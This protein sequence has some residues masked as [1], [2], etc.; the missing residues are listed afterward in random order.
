MATNYP[1]GLDSLSNPAGSD[2]LSTGHAAQHANAND[3]IE[4]I[5]GELGLNPRGGSATVKARIDAIEANSWVTSARIADG[6]VTGTDIA[7]GTVT[8]ANLVDGTIVNADIN[9]AAA[10]DKT[11]ISGTAVTTADSGSVT[12]GM[13]LDGTIVNT[14]VNASAA[15]AATK[16]AGTA[17]TQA[18]TGTVTSAMIATGAIVD[19]DINAAAGIAATKVS[20]TAVTQADSGTVTSAMIADGTIVN[21]DIATAAAVAPSKID[22]AR[23]TFSNAA[24]VCAATTRKLAQVGTMSASRTV[25][26]PAANAVA[27]GTEIVICDESGSVTTTNT[28]VIARAGTDTINGTTSVSIGAAYG[29]RRAISDGSSKWSVDGGVVRLSDVGTITSTMIADATITGADIATGTVESANI[30]DGTI[31]NA[32]INA[33]AAIDATKIAGISASA[34]IGN[35]LTTN[36][37]SIETN[38]TG[39]TAYKCTLARSS[40]EALSGTY[41]LAAT[42]T[43]TPDY[44]I[45]TPTGTSGVPV[46]PGQTYT[47]MVYGKAGTTTTNH[48]AYLR[49][50]TAAGAFVSEVLSSIT[51]ITSA[52]WTQ[53]VVTATAPATA[54][55]ANPYV[56]ATSG[57]TAGEVYY[58]DQWGLW[59]GTGGLWRLPGTPIPNM[60]TYTDESV[61]RRIF[62]WDTVNSR[63]QM[64]YGDTGWR[65]VSTLMTTPEHVQTLT[66]LRLRRQGSTVHFMVRATVGTG[67]VFGTVTDI[68]L[69]SIP[70]GFA[71][72]DY[73]T[74]GSGRQT[75]MPVHLVT[76][77]ASNLMV[78]NLYSGNWT[79]ADLLGRGTWATS[80][81]WPTALP[82]S[83]VGTIPV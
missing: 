77:G 55:F 62:T 75:R 12:S 82:G 63:W 57:V 69:L 51:A 28:I 68:A 31:V 65:D 45:Y 34:T 52:G 22:Q 15:I 74:V 33:S 43:G 66:T 13:I 2:A 21:A 4:A 32:D 6:T 18:D 25:T 30:L 81:A 23:V 73:V 24:A 46:V 47:F 3:A 27:A 41:S 1:S 67:T 8:S 83:A 79:A 14:D 26:L 7:S 37:A 40:A 54:A 19:A 35:L 42:I 60:G 50:Y 5:E 78:A 36:Q 70:T 72:D 17:V 71:P 61:G 56:S 76:S 64:T 16:I 44:A 48:R 49:W 29:M 20:G 10:I 58:F 11:K 59:S 80:A 39:F 53:M 38:T 9:A